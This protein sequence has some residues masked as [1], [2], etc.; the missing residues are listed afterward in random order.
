M[1]AFDVIN[2]I[3]ALIGGAVILAMPIVILILWKRS[4][5]F[6]DLYIE[7]RQDYL[8]LKNN[9]EEINEHARNL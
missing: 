9:D 5:D 3:F 2:S 7:A 6:R 8:R 4:N 1:S